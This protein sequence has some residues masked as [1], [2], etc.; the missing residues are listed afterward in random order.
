MAIYAE[1]TSGIR[2]FMAFPIFSGVRLA[3]IFA[4]LLGATDYLFLLMTSVQYPAKN[5]LRKHFR[6]SGQAFKTMATHKGRK[7]FSSLGIVASSAC[8][9]KT[10]WLT[11][12][13][14]GTMCWK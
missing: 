3:L 11:S 13:P 14:I 2:S 5:E 10:I 9:N 1:A 6:S 4:S 12:M 7:T 8:V